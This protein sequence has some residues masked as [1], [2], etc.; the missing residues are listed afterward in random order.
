MIVSGERVRRM[1]GLP[2]ARSDSQFSSDLLTWTDQQDQR[3]YG[4]FVN[5]ETSPLFQLLEGQT[6]SIRYDPLRPN[7]FYNRAHARAWAL[8]LT[9]ATLAVVLGGGFIAWRIWMIV[10]RRGY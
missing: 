9:K 2:T 8:M 10:T 3:Q 1:F 5:Q 4:P 7:C 6:I